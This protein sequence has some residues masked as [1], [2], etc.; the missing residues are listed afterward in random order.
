MMQHAREQ[1][2]MPNWIRQVWA[3]ALALAVLS[4]LIFP[5]AVSLFLLFVITSVYSYVAYRHTLIS[6]KRMLLEIP[7]WAAIYVVI[8]IISDIL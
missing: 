2:T 3:I 1:T 5:L 7:T 8:F 6:K 4:A